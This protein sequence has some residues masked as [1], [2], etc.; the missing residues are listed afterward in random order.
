M[1][2]SAKTEKEWNELVNSIKT[3]KEASK[4]KFWKRIIKELKKSSK[5][6]REVNIYKIDKHMRKE[7]TAVVPGKVLSQGEL[8]KEIT[9]A[10]YKF[11]DSAKKKINS[12]G[13]AISL[14]QLLKENPKAKRVRIIG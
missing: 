10:A 13:K 12:K 1:K 14:K 9:V 8:T 6:R 5:Q 11:S 3:N 2:K 4:T 7:E